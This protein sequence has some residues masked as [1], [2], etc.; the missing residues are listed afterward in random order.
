MK[1]NQD[2]NTVNFI[3]IKLSDE[4]TKPDFLLFVCSACNGTG[5][6]QNVD[7]SISSSM[8]PCL[9]CRGSGVTSQY[10]IDWHMRGINQ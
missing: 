3:T 9:V 2:N 10:D 8:G 7:F 4:Y 1:H 6:T 5:L